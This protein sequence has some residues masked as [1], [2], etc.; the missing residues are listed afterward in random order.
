[1]MELDNAVNLTPQYPEVYIQRALLK[2]KLGMRSEANEDIAIAARLNPIAPALYGVRGPQAQMDLLA[3]Y[4]EELYQEIS[5]S[6]RLA[7]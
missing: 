2:Y 3:F 1:M 6:D 7:Y 5:W 4:P